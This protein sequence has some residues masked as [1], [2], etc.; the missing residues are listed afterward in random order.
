[1]SDPSTSNFTLVSPRPS[2][3]LPR[4]VGGG[5]LL[6]CAH[7]H[8]H[9]AGRFDGGSPSGDHVAEVGSN[10]S[11]GV[12]VVVGVGSEAKLV[13]LPMKTCSLN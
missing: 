11:Q 8:G 13:I 3:L 6:A 4:G 10:F 5:R 12:Y 1:M 2:V 9:G 7:G